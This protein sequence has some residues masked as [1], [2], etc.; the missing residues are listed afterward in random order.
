MKVLARLL[1]IIVVIGVV[2]GF[3]LY[4]LYE[5]D[6]PS[7]LE[8]VATSETASS[9]I[10]LNEVMAQNKGVYPDETGNYSDWVEIYNPT[11]RAVDLHNYALTDDEKEPTKWPFPNAE[12]KAGGYLVIFLSG[13]STVDLEH[14]VIHSTIKLSSKGDKLILTNMAGQKLDAIP[15]YKTMPA[16]VSLGRVGDKWEEFNKPTP[17]FENSDEGYKAFQKSMVVEDSPLWINEVMT[18]NNITIMDNTSAFSD[19]VEV[20]NISDKDVS[21]KGLGLTDNPLDPLKWRFPDITLKPGEIQLVFCSGNPEA[22]DKDP[23]KGLHTNFRLASYKET[24]ELTNARGMVMDRVDVK[25]IPSDTS[26]AR[27]YEGDKP[28]KDWAETGK[29]TPGYPNTDAGF[30]EYP[31]KQQGGADGYHHLRGDVFQQ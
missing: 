16:N 31:E 13:K 3:I 5:G 19:W 9:G 25:S 28:T 15:E 6:T 11:E 26:Y 24:V 20:V 30:A 21:L 29:P 4:K 2:V 27:T 23:K 7:Q 12:L 18:S 8:G 14:G 1:I 17:G 22:T 10:I